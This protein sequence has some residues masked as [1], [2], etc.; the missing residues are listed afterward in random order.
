MGGGG[1]AEVSVAAEEAER[2][3]ELELEEAVPESQRR[4]APDSPPPLRLELR[5][6][7]ASDSVGV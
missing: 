4:F 5:S 2:T 1:E 3:D 7:A 6:W